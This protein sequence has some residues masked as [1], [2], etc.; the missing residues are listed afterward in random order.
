MLFHSIAV[1]LIIIEGL[2]IF[3]ILCTSSSYKK[4]KKKTGEKMETKTTIVDSLSSFT[5]S[6]PDSLSN[7]VFSFPPRIF[8]YLPQYIST[9]TQPKTWA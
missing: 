6:C 7:R 1:C 9:K 4:N 8:N 2:C 3:Y 5:E